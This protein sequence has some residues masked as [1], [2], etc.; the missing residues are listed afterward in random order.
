[1]S[2]ES[3]QAHAAQKS[4]WSASRTACSRAG[5]GPGPLAARK[6]GA[7]SASRC[8]SPRAAAGTSCSRNSD[9]GAPRGRLA[10][11]PPGAPP[12]RLAQVLACLLYDP[13]EEPRAGPPE[14]DAMGKRLNDLSKNWGTT[15]TTRAMSQR[16]R[17]PSSR[18]CASATICSRAEPWTS[19]PR[20]GAGAGA[21]SGAGA[22]VADERPAR[23]AGAP[24]LRSAHCTTNCATCQNAQVCYHELRDD[25]E[26]LAVGARDLAARSAQSS[27]LRLDLR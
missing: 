27:V 14:R 7:P 15:W 22:G 12:G 8:L 6:T 9:P 18:S 10:G 5:A 2:R 21:G 17:C 19:G 13:R 3:R 16:R 1:M 11:A 25:P 23:G 4:S 26:Y 24:P 20:A